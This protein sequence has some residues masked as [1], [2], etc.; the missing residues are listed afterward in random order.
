M[1]AL[2]RVAQN[3]SFHV[4]D[5]FVEGDFFFIVSVVFFFDVIG[6]TY[7]LHEYQIGN[8]KQF[9]GYFRCLNSKEM[10]AF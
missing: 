1:T 2:N 4:I 3:S 7:T 9:D 5:A 8:N 10:G 6:K